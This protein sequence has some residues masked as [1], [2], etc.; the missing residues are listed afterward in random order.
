MR[1]VRGV[2]R[3]GPESRFVGAAEKAGPGGGEERAHLRG[4]FDGPPRAAVRLQDHRPIV[5]RAGD[6]PIGFDPPGVAQ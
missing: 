2:T 1:N 6:D 4:R 3:E 5:Y